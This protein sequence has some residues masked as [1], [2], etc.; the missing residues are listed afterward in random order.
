MRYKEFNRNKVLEQCIPLFWYNGFNSTAV[1]DVVRETG[2]N[3]FS[4]YEEFKNK[5][6]ILYAS[7]KLYHDRYSSKNLKIL[8][9]WSGKE[10]RETL[11]NFYLSFLV[12]RDSH[13]PGCYIIHIAT[14][15]ADDDPRV[16]EMLDSFF[17]EVEE[18]LVE[19]LSSNEKT[20]QDARFY[21]RHLIGLLCASTTFCL[22][23]SEEERIEHIDNGIN[24]ILDKKSEEYATNAE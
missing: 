9:P 15:L 4:L 23:H 1:S 11:R 12:N 6:G 8:D 2:V 17:S 19:V 21:A 3:R 20:E 24:V 16:K 22:I 18:R 14:E 7:L 13:P 5:E 10:P